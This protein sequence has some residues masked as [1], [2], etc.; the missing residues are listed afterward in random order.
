MYNCLFFKK[1]SER[2]VIINTIPKAGT[3]LAVGLIGSFG[4]RKIAIKRGFRPWLFDSKKDLL[5]SLGSLTSGL[6]YNAHLEY[7]VEVATALTKSGAINVFVK[8]DLNDLIY[9]HWFYLKYIEK[10]HRSY[11]SS[12]SDIEILRAI[13][14][15]VEA[16]SGLKE[17]YRKYMMWTEME[18]VY[19]VDYEDLL[20]WKKEKKIPDSLEGVFG[21][22]IIRF[23]NFCNLYSQ[24]N[25]FKLKNQYSENKTRITQLVKDVCI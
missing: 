18:G 12:L 20:N 3:N 8:R 21:N 19:I 25:T 2:P 15:G 9:S 13:W 16:G 1:S 11:D 7:D 24:T 23:P 22:E 10:N 17:S 5:W 4:I 14:F 6:V